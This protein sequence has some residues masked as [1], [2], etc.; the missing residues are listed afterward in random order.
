MATLERSSR[1]ARFAAYTI[2]FIILSFPNVIFKNSF[3][4]LVIYFSYFWLSSYFYGATI[5]KKLFDLRVVDDKTG[6]KLTLGQAFIREVVGRFVSAVVF[7]LGFIWILFDEK[8]QGWHDKIANTIVVQDKE[9]K[10]S[11]K[12]IAY[13]LVFVGPLLFVTLLVIGV[14]AGLFLAFI[15]PSAQI[16]KAQQQQLQQQYLQQQ[17]YFK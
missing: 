1:L 2:D 17:Q 4:S 8:R 5:G 13:I 10:G 3:L 7:A 9:L 16:Q 6:K 14:L 15:N 11:K 12:I